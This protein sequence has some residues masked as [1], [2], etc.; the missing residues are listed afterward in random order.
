MSRRRTRVAILSAM[1]IIGGAVP[2]A[3][4]A[5]HAV[6]GDAPWEGRARIYI[7][8][9]Q[10]AFVLGAFTGR[11]AVNPESSVLHGAQLV[12]PGAFDADYAANTTRGEGHCIITTGSGDRIFASWS[13]AGQPDKGCSGRFVLTGGTGAYQGVTGDG[14]LALRMTLSEMTRLEQLESDYDV[15]GLATWPELR[16]RTP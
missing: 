6:R 11:L 3:R 7:T 5:E 8:G 12:C 4:G 1:M 16:Y 10:Q 14:D 13:C 2:G 15:K 9:P